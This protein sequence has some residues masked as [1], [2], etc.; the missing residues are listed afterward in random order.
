ME[1]DND[2][3]ARDCMTL[4]REKSENVKKIEVLRKSSNELQSSAEE[5][6]LKM[7]ENMKLTADKVKILTEEVIIYFLL[8]NLVSVVLHRY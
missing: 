8:N 3:L 1:K 6:I 2:R 4:Q 5:K 7:R